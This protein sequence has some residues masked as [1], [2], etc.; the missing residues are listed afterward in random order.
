MS[1][2]K[3]VKYLVVHCAATPP[4]MDIGAKEI[5]QWH[6]KR[7]WADIGYHRIIRRDGT[8]EEGRPEHVAGAHVRGFNRVSLAVCLVGGVDDENKPEDNF[9]KEQFSS[10]KSLLD[11]WA[12]KYPEAEIRGHRDFPGVKKACPSFDVK[13]WIKENF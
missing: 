8:I 7:G 9:T 10:L 5:R 6:L 1:L 13:K 2:I 4:S 11:Q 3:E 12:E